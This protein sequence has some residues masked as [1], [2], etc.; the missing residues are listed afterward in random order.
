MKAIVCTQY[1]PPEVLQLKEVEKPVPRNNEVCIK[2]HATS[3]T[4]SD[5]IV[6]GGKVSWKLWLA[7]RLAMG[8][9]KPRNILGFVVAGEIESVGKDVKL[10]RKGDQVFGLTLKPSGLQSRSGTYAEYKCLLE[11]SLLARKPSDI[12]YEEAAAV[13]YGGMLALHFLKKGDIQ[14]RQRV[15]IYGASGAIGTSAVQLAKYFGATV[16]GIC[17]TSN[18][19]LVKSLGADTVIDYSKEDFTIRG[20]LYDLILDA[21]P[22]GKI[23]RKSLKLRCITSLS[24]NGE[25]IAL[26]DERPVFSKENL[27]LLKELVVT[28]EFK[29]V[30]DRCYPLEQTAEA[31]R[32]VELGHKK[33]NVVITI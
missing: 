10:F 8:F 29:P 5:I 14:N 22:A 26:D 17:S 2:I 33:G 18:L 7:M 12:T 1:G 16:T 27:A 23:N 21:V 30:V 28:G 9:T 13:P 31:H 11:D 15:L 19:D 3:I 20:E 4:G 25:Y 24:P 6:R 32:Y